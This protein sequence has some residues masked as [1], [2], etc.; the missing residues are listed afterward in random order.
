MKTVRAVILKMVPLVE[1]MISYKMKQAGYGDLMADAWTKISTHYF[2][3][4]GK[5]NV[6]IK[7]TVGD[8]VFKLLVPKQ[9]LLVMS[10]L[11]TWIEDEKDSN[12]RTEATNF[13]AEGIAQ[14][15]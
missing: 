12:K 13:K 7:Q 3:L 4:F 9:V 15:V 14:F 2:G 6:R 5:N 10:P 8:E 1:K 11:T